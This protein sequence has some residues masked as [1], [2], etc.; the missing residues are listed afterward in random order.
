MFGGAAVCVG[1]ALVEAAGGGGAEEAGQAAAGGDGVDDLAAGV[2]AAGAW[3]ACSLWIRNEKVS[4]WLC[5]SQDNTWSKSI[6][7]EL[8]VL[9]LLSEGGEPF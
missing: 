9:P 1:L 2:G 7:T 4:L 5:C 6:P 8:A 3:V